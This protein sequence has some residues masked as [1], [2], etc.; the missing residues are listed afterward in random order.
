MTLSSVGPRHARRR[1]ARRSARARLAWAGAALRRPRR[2]GGLRACHR[3]SA[4]RPCPVRRAVPRLGR[5]LCPAGHG[6]GEPAA[7]AP[8]WSPRWRCG[9]PSAPFTPSLSDDAYR[10][11]WDG[12]V[13]LAGQNPYRFAPADRRLDGV[14]YADRGRINHPRLRTVYPPLAELGFAAV[15]AVH[16]GAA[17]L[18]GPLRPGRP[19][20]R[21]L[22]LVACRRGAA[23]H[24]ASCSTCCARRSC[25]RPGRPPTWRSSRWPLVRARRRAACVGA[26]TAGLAW[27]WGS[28]GR[29]S[30]RPS[31][32]SCR[33]CW[34]GGR[35]PP[36][37]S[38]VC[39]RRCSCLTCPTSCT[40][41][42]SARCSTAA[43]PG[44]AAR[45][46]S[47][48]LRVVL[49]AATARA[50][51]RGAGRRRRRLA[52]HC[53]CVVGRQTA[54][55]FAWTATLLVV[56][57]PVVHAWYWLTPLALGLAAGE[58]LPVALG[59]RL[60]CPRRSRPPCRLAAC[61]PS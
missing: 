53:A 31:C 7:G 36:A 16:G 10:Y 56:C 60:P 5:W 42:P 27:P 46:S 29:S 48:P 32:W 49:P 6:S 34:A 12:K 61:L 2:P 18:Q 28:P 4:C 17:R 47:S 25:C 14:R 45:W 59:L 38:P 8:C 15:A 1:C 37:S 21:R 23:S 40:A 41:A 43:P 19:G 3:R 58:R 24:R 26:A 13:Q 57:L 9:L 11:V 55:V 50:R 20:R 33:R 52:S 54:R 22:G 44:S 30:S 39:C 51:L 35:S